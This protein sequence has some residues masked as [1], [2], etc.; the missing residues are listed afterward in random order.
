MPD[1]KVRSISGWITL[2][3]GGPVV[4]S[5]HDTVGGWRSG[6]TV[7]GTEYPVTGDK[8]GSTGV[9]TG[10]KLERSLP[11]PFTYGGDITASNNT[12]APG[13]SCGCQSEQSEDHQKFHVSDSV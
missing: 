12:A 1:D 9:R 5:K 10:G 7:S 6:D 8:D 3:L 11:G 2:T 13:V 4:K